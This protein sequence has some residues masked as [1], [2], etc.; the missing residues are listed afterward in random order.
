MRLFSL[1]LLWFLYYQNIF[2]D[3]KNSKLNKNKETQRNHNHFFLFVQSAEFTNL[4]SINLNSEEKYDTVFQ[5]SPDFCP[6]FTFGDRVTSFGDYL[7]PRKYLGGSS[8]FGR[9]VKSTCHAEAPETPHILWGR[10]QIPINLYN[11]KYDFTN[12]PNGF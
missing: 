8:S 10:S 1:L 11:A 7:M 12:N 4:S 2:W 3:S 9:E 6:V 5:E